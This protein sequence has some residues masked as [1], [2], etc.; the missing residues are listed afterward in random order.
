M[1]VFISDKRL[2]EHL[3]RLRT[4]LEQRL[5][6]LQQ[7]VLQQPFPDTGASERALAAVLEQVEAG[8]ARLQAS[9]GTDAAAPV[10]T[11]EQAAQQLSRMEAALAALTSQVAALAAVTAPAAQATGTADTDPA[12]NTDPTEDTVQSA[13]PG[14]GLHRPAPQSLERLLATL[15]RAA[16]VSTAELVCHPHTWAFIERHLAEQDLAHQL[17]PEPAATEHENQAGAL[18]TA[19]VS[20]PVLMGILTALHQCAQYDAANPLARAGMTD[21]AM[22]R[23]LFER[24]SD[25]VDTVG[26]PPAD[27]QA[28]DGP[29]RISFDDR[30]GAAANPSPDGGQFAEHPLIPGGSDADAAP[31]PAEPESVGGGQDS[32]PF[33]AADPG[34]LTI[35]GPLY[36]LAVVYLLGGNPYHA[37]HPLTC[38]A[39]THAG[40]RCRNPLTFGEHPALVTYTTDNG[41]TARAYDVGDDPRW[42]AQHCPTHVDHTDDYIT[43]Q[44]IPVDPAPPTP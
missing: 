5:D 27:G 6:E 15:Q 7:Q 35:P 30:T 36:G 22:A 38:V 20:G 42:K 40:T 43:P 31:E 44:W 33:D 18:V 4:A 19:A 34:P 1:A 23:S 10:R 26:P 12:Q 32:V 29:T 25:T 21:I 14:A 11:G 16:L 2:T 24:I 8:F 37:P 28:P 9:S 13:R 17:L 39:R 41:Q 3:S